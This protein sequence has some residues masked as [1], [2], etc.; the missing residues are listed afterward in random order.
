MMK[1][2]DRN[3]LMLKIQE[4]EFATLEFNLYLD[5]H[6]Q[7][8]NAL[9]EFNKLTC[10]GENLRKLYCNYYGPLVNFG[11]NA[12]SYPWNWVDGPWP[13]EN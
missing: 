8:C 12:S 3:E 9:A 7:D 1:K 10:E 2:I 4:I 5:T 6:P 11:F 13:W